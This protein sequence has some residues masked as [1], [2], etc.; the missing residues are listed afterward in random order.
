M[1]SVGTRH[2]GTYTTQPIDAIGSV[3]VKIYDTNGR[4][5]RTLLQTTQGPGRHPVIFDGTDDNNENLASGVYFARVH[6]GEWSQVEKISL[7]K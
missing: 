1:S 4:L 3:S 7:L 6:A 5:V 2:R